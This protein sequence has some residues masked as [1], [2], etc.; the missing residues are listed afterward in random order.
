MEKTLKPSEN[1]LGVRSFGTLLEISVVLHF[2]NIVTITQFIY[3]WKVTLH[4]TWQLSKLDYICPCLKD[5][6]NTIV[7]YFLLTIWQFLG[8]NLSQHF[9]ATALVTANP[10]SE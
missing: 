3:K 5:S 8:T 6:N 10:F 4:N 2:S 9:I 1:Y 7:R